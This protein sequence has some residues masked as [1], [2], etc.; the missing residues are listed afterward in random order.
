MRN[1]QQFYLLVILLCCATSF[2]G[3]ATFGIALFYKKAKLPNSQIVRDVKYSDA[4]DADVNRNSLNLFLPEGKNWPTMVFVHGG[5]WNEGDKNLKVAG[6]DVYNNIGRYFASQGIATAVINY[7]LLPKVD[8]RAQVLDVA[9]A[10][11]WIYRHIQEYHG[12]PHAIFLVGHSA[13][14]QLASRVALDN[15]FLNSLGLSPQIIRGVIPISGVGYN[16]LDKEMYQFGQKK[17]SIQENFHTDDISR[18]FRKKLSPIFYAKRVSP[19]FLILYAAHDP[20]E[21]KHASQK[22]DTTLMKVGAESQLYLIPKQNHKS[23]ILALS[24]AKIPATLIELFMKTLSR[25][26]AR[27]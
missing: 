20:K 19:P 21:I 11:G 8:W 5:G 3:C 13:G 15:S 9:K 7:G 17:D 23:M 25:A 24:R 6:A 14:A 10:T 12:D 27:H 16:F 2:S 22:L 4:L 18:S 1:K 26:E